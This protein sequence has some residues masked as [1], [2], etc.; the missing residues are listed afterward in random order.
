MRTIFRRLTQSL[1]ISILSVIVLG[2]SAYAVNI[3]ATVPA[4]LPIT[5]SSDGAVT[6]ATN[7]AI[8]NY[9]S[10]PIFVSS[11]NVTAENG[12]SLATKD[13][14]VSA[15]IGAKVISMGFNGSWMDASGAVDTS[16]F[17]RISSSGTLNL[18]YDAKT[19]GV[20]TAESSST[21]ATATFVVGLP[22]APTMASGSSWYKSTENRNTITKITFMDS[23]TP[24]TEADETWFA[25]ENNNGDITC[26][27]TGTEIIIAGNGAG[28]IKANADSSHMFSFSSYDSEFRKLTSIDNISL[29]DTTGVTQM[30]AMFYNC[31]SLASLNVSNFNMSNV[32]NTRYMFSNCSSLISSDVSHWDVSNINNMYEMFWRCENLKNL[33]VSNWDT[34]SVKDMGGMFYF[35]N[36]LTT[37]N[38]SGWNTSNVTDMSFMFADCSG[39]TSLD[40]SKWNTANVTN[41]K[42]LFHDC[43]SLTVLDV[44]KWNTS[45][46]T[47]M[48]ALF[49]HCDSLINA[50]VS[51]WNTS[52][53][54]DFSLIFSNCGKLTTLDVSHFDTSNA[55]DMSQMFY[56]CGG[57]TNLD[58]SSFNTSKVT[59]TGSMFFGCNG[60]SNIDVSNFDTANVTNMAQMFYS[61][62]GLTILDL[63]NF[64]TSNVTT[65]Y[66]MFFD[67]SSLTTIYASNKWSIDALTSSESM[68]YNCIKLKGDIAYTSGY[69]D[70]TYAKIHEG[71]LTDREQP[72]TLAAGPSWYKSEQNRNTITKITFMDSYTP[73]SY[74][75]KWAADVDGTGDI[76]CYRTGTEIIIAGNGAGKIKANA[77]SR[78]LFSVSDSSSNGTGKIKANADSRS[79]FP[80]IHFP[81]TFT[82]LTSIE[83]LAL[84]D[85]A[86]VTNMSSMFIGCSD[87]TS[88][89]L[90]HFNTANVTNISG[91]FN[92]CNDLTSLNLSNFNTA[93]V[94]DMSFMFSF[95]SGLTSL[96]VSNF[97]TANVTNMSSMFDSCRGLTSLDVSNF[98]TANVTRM[99]YMFD[100][101]RG[102]TSLNLSNFN[103]ANVTD[104]SFMFSFCSG[105]T[106]LDVSNFDTAN[107]TDMGTMF[108][109][110]SG[111]TTIYAGDAW[112]TDKVTY[113]NYM[114]EN[115]EKLKGAISYDTSKTDA[116][117]ANWTTGYFTY[118]AA[119]TKTL[120]LNID[121]NS[122][123][124]TSYDVSTNPISRFRAFLDWSDT[125]NVA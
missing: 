45:K 21:A 97:D 41:M 110:C 61:C 66:R 74:D 64:D 58:V 70:K 49:W 2:C 100:S 117:Y 11:I 106:S 29:L 102:L 91:M 12:W 59:S 114:F 7:A 78:F 1:I 68:F 55:I 35:C 115:C 87:L 5:V 118:K 124:V 72:A 28:K 82:N 37:L 92:S 24:S 57:L 22:S 53:V 80:E 103:T 56:S 95:C 108:Y 79:L 40:V 39:L 65:M 34:S 81:S 19:P 99:D 119:S 107:V 121:S 15:S 18:S 86:N 113:S 10:S 76:T 4:S 8:H 89:D 94:T 120:S 101:C 77:D 43:S 84:L 93:N 9:G 71:Y 6:T 16:G 33:D 36:S 50:D 122:G 54:T 73:A 38:V 62:S 112:N 3:D 109:S 75:E 27:R 116:T 47:N 13:A 25:D 111:L 42:E 104:M 26:Y 51:D 69:T 105:L 17:D 23:Y 96:D 20:V 30:R 83:N 85:T 32:V 46:T 98:D 67:D 44:S 52:N 60:L 14:A 123:A 31:Q 63:S 88:L 48:C 125:A 90:S